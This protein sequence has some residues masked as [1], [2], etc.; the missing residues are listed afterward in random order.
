[1][2]QTQSFNGDLLFHRRRTEGCSR[3]P[4][5][6]PLAEQIISWAHSQSRKQALVS[7]LRCTP[8]WQRYK[9]GPMR[10]R[11]IDFEHRFNTSRWAEDLLIQALGA[12]HGLIT[13]RFGLS[14][15]RAVAQLV[16]GLTSY[17]EPDLLVFSMKSL[18]ENKQK[19][20][21]TENLEK[22]DRNL[23]V[24][25]GELEFVFQKA[26]AAIEVE[27]SPYRAKEMKGHDWQPKS[28]EKWER[29]PL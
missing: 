29:R 15:V 20:L 22:A 18:S 4:S 24:T 2:R 5:A 9:R 6:F 14:E 12:D 27:F 16:Y 28:L 3:A 1:M 19:I 13:V 23:F 26:L 7:W 11:G 25:G 10:G 8:Q 17:K 21:A